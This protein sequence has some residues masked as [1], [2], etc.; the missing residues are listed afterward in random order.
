MISNGRT[1]KNTMVCFE[2]DRY[3]AGT[4][5]LFFE[6]HNY[7]FMI[8]DMDD[9]PRARCSWPIGSQDSPNSHVPLV[10]QATGRKEDTFDHFGAIG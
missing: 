5:Q 10:A 9:F 3:C 4:R 2:T 8:S 7:C 6:D 1:I